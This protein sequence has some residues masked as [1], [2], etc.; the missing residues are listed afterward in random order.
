LLAGERVSFPPGAVP[1]DE[2]YGILA[3]RFSPHD[4]EFNAE[5]IQNMIVQDLQATQ[6]NGISM[7]ID[8][9]RQ[10][11]RFDL[12]LQFGSSG[13]NVLT[14]LGDAEIGLPSTRTNPYRLLE[15]GVDKV[16]PPELPAAF[17]ERLTE[18]VAVRGGRWE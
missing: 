4:E 2:I 11:S 3:K 8:F 16:A 5:Q 1:N 15:A 13:A 6:K 9:N 14:Q 18:D 17:S 7:Q 12:L 10:F